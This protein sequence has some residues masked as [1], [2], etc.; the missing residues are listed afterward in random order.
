MGFAPDKGSGADTGR[1]RAQRFT[2]AAGASKW[3]SVLPIEHHA[4]GH[5][6]SRGRLKKRDRAKPSF[7]DRRGSL[8]SILDNFCPQLAAP[9]SIAS[10]GWPIRDLQRRARSARISPLARGTIRGEHPSMY[11]GM[12][13]MDGL[14]GWWELVD[15]SA[16]A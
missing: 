6:Q 2:G 3:W 10:P 8:A 4:G 15:S 5:G 9:A 1:I 11:R 16:A 14:S 7:I 12:T 13:R